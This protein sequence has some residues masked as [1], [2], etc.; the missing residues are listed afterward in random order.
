MGSTSS[1]PYD[2]AS[3]DERQPKML[4]RNSSNSISQDVA[5]HMPNVNATSSSTFILSFENST[6]KPRP[7]NSPMYFDQVTKP[8]AKQG[9]KKYR[10]SSEIQ[11]HIMTERRRRQELTERFIA[12]SATIPGL[13]KVSSTIST[14]K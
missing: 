9:T 5:P 14:E 10:S 11:D 6:M 13:K 8:K 4:K 2:D 12:L 7:N 3:F 1:L